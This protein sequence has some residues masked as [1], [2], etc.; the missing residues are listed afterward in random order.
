MDEFTKNLIKFITK[1]I[2]CGDSDEKIAEQMD[3]YT[4]NRQDLI[5]VIRCLISR[6]EG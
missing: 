5:A 2:Q 3:V 6:K 4:A 1:S